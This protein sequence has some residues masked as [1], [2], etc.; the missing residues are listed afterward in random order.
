MIVQPSGQ[1]KRIT[2]Y[3]LAIQEASNDWLKGKDFKSSVV[4]SFSYK[5]ETYGSDIFNLVPH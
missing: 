1:I 4:V 5:N 3:F 2:L